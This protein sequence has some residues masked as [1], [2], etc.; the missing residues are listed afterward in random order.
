VLL[1]F[2]HQALCRLGLYLAAGC[3]SRC[4][5]TCCSVTHLITYAWLGLACWWSALA[6]AE[7]GL[8]CGLSCASDIAYCRGGNGAPESFGVLLR[9]G[10]AGG[11]L[12]FVHDVA[13]LCLT[14]LPLLSRSCACGVVTFE[15]H[16]RGCLHPVLAHLPWIHGCEVG[17]HC[18]CFVYRL[19]LSVESCTARLLAGCFRVSWRVVLG[20]VPDRLSGWWHVVG[21]GRLGVSVAVPV[22]QVSMSGH[23]PLCVLPGLCGSCCTLLL[24]IFALVFGTG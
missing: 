11:C 20:G 2:H 5:Y 13:T 10:I 15:Q 4:S 8:S 6:A 1:C 3:Q 22:L 14:D 16:V 18:G 23:R 12:Y 17:R 19:V 21:W 9:F 7:P 24:P